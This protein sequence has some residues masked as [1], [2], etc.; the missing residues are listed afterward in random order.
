MAYEDDIVD[1]E[2]KPKL[3][4]PSNEDRLHEVFTR[5]I[6]EFDDVQAAVKEE[7]EQSR[8]DRRFASIAGAQYEGWLADQMENRP[9]FEV[10]KVALAVIRIFNEYRN[11]RIDVLF[12]SKDG[13]ESDDLADTCNGLYR[14]DEKDSCA[15]EAYDNAFDES[16]T[17]GMGAYE[18]C[19]EYEDDEDP[20]NEQQ[21]IRILPIFDADKRVFFNLGA[22]RQDKSD[23]TC[24]WVLY[25][26]TPDDYKAKWG[27]D[28][29]SWPQSISD[30]WNNFDW[31]TTDAVYT[32]D[33]Y[34]VEN[35][36]ETY[37]WF[38]GLTG[39]EVRHTLSELRGDAGGLSSTLAK[40][41]EATGYIE[42]RRKRVKERSVHKYIMSGAGVLEDCGLV[43]GKHIPIVPQYGK[44][45]Y[46][47]GVERFMGHVRLAKDPQRI[48]NLT[49]SKIAE[50]SAMASHEVPIVSPEQIAGHQLLWSEQNVK[51]NPYLLLNMVKDLNGNPIQS[52]PI[53]Y[54]HPPQ[55]PPALAALA[56]ISEQDIND[57]LGNQQAGEQLTPNISGKA[58]E[59]IQ[60]KL[61]MQAFIY[62]SNAAKARR[63][64]GEIWLSMAKEVYCEEGRTMKAVGSQG[65]IN[66][67]ELQRPIVSE[68]GTIGTENDITC[69]TF[70]VDVEV[71]PSSQSKRA[72]TVRAITGMMSITQDQET[73]QVLGA[74]AM[75]NMEGEGLADAKAYFRKKRLKMGIGK[76]T[77][78]EA[79]EFAAEQANAQ[80]DPNAEFLRASAMEAA[81]KAKQAEADAVFTVAKTEQTQAKT[82]ETL[83]GI[84]INK[85]AHAVDTAIKIDQALQATGGPARTAETQ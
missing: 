32:A 64:G 42:S 44:R 27:D 53:G 5:A 61:D 3:G 10:N 40:R 82:I 84:D 83:A 35:V 16:T 17:G 37:V 24:C 59:L 1:S 62:M 6:K 77:D 8:D 60:N 73:L 39:D 2:D 14:A 21:R 41:L 75:E 68:D 7:R 70:D 11:N 25:P 76:P 74:M 31:R 36:T 9:Q 49:V 79:K 51:Q 28:P 19:C 78:E 43:P 71:G 66:S 26:Y 58:V 72:A 69:A 85:Q 57:V 50:I 33:Y 34:E 52:G 55:I 38:R 45:W 67:V 63:R 80:P 30:N 65:E 29:V 23:A 22:Q 47:D 13:S 81:A 12:T 20:D 54:T 15:E 56:Q 46:I 18:L 4:R 48:K